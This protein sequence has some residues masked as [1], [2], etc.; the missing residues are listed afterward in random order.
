MIIKRKQAET[1]GFKGCN[2][3]DDS[4][5]HSFYR[6]VIPRLGQ[7]FV[8]GNL[9]PSHVA[10]YDLTPQQMRDWQNG[11][12]GITPIGC[13]NATGGRTLSR[14]AQFIKTVY[15]FRNMKHLLQSLQQI[16]FPIKDALKKKGIE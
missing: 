3:Y 4:A 15:D 1:L 6:C 8:I 2:M 16:G 10:R 7:I 9:F 13:C 5:C 14:P 12:L 11:K